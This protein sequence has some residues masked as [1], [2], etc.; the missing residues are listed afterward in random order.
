LIAQPSSHLRHVAGLELRA[1]LVVHC[2]LWLGRLRISLYQRRTT[3]GGA[4]PVD[5]SQVAD[6]GGVGRDAGGK[7]AA[8]KA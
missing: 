8:P 7:P 2:L 4:G 5:Q 1:I 3:R 6:D